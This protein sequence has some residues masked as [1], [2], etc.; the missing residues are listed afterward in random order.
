MHPDLG[1]PASGTVGIGA[2]RVCGPLLLAA[3]RECNL[4]ST[5]LTLCGPHIP[6]SHFPLRTVQGSQP[7]VL[8]I[9]GVLTWAASHLDT[10]LEVSPPEPGSFST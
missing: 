4:G 3:P 7:S 1:R 8:P 6:T 5:R 9:R 2:G 10:H